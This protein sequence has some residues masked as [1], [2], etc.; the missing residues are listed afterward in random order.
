MKAFWKTNMKASMFYFKE[1]KLLKKMK[2]QE[3]CQVPKS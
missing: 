3:S 2:T 1:I